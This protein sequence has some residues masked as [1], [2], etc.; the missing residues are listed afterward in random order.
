[1]RDHLERISRLHFIHAATELEDELSAPH[2]TG[3]PSLFH[4]VIPSTELS[5]VKAG[6]M[7]LRR[8][9]CSQSL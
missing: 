6:A 2:F 4:A 1:V 7:I 9:S 3:I 5:R 8:W